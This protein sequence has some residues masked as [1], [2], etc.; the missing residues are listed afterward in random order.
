MKQ[1]MKKYFWL[2]VAAVLLSGCSI[3]KKKSDQSG[4]ATSLFGTEWRL[5]S[6]GSKQ[7]K[8]KEDRETV[9]LLVT[10]DPEN[11][12][13]F[14]GCNRYFGKFTSKKDKLSFSQMACTLMACPEQDMDLERRYLES[15]EKVNNYTIEND[16]LFLRKDEKVLL[17]FAQ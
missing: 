9:T 10:R 3:F 13:G 17:I 7:M 16:T 11:V 15:L 1:G 4:D 8:Y 12:S 14:S 6:I 5:C 2:S